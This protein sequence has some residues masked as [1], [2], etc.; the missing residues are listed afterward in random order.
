VRS[1]RDDTEEIKT[2]THSQ[3]LD[4][5][6][7]RTRILKSRARASRLVQSGKIRLTRN[8]DTH[9]IKKSHICI[10][11]GDEITFMRGKTLIHVEILQIGTRRG[12]ASEAQMLYRKIPREPQN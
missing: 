1:V 2:T 6:L 8:G 7:F 11:P 5:W 10:Q 9:R 4:L 3:R 12:P